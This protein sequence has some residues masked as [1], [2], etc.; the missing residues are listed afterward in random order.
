[1]SG[2]SS[3]TSTGQ[4]DPTL[5]PLFRG[6]ASR[7]LDVQANNPLQGYNQQM[8]MDVAGMSNPELYA[9]SQAYGLGQADPLEAMEHLSR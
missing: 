4:I 9:T 5:Q 7:L 8:P 3:T 6:S 2:S 1:M